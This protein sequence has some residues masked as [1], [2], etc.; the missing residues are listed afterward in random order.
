LVAADAVGRAMSDFQDTA[1]Q[2][3]FAAGL[4][5]FARTADFR[6]YTDGESP[7][8]V[9]PANRYLIAR[10]VVG[11]WKEDARG[12]SADSS[13]AYSVGELLNG[14]Q[15]SSHAYL[16]IWQYDPRVASWGLRVLLINPLGR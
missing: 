15:R 4:R 13:F 10:A 11:A 1:V 7:M 3:G 12:R 6:F 9:S 14:Q 2:D 16:Q 8:G 5:T